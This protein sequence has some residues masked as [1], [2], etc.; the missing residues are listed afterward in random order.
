M[1]RV[2]RKKELAR[3]IYRISV[4]A[5]HIARKRRAGQF[6]IVVA[7]EGGE[8]VP[9]TIMTSDTEAGT[10]DLVFLVAGTSTGELSLLEEGGAIPHVVGPLGSP[11]DIHK[12]GTV[13]VVGGGVGAAAAC[14][15]AEAIAAAG[16]TLISIVGA[17]SKDL[18]ILEDDFAAFS[19]KLIVCT[20]D[21]SYGKAGFVTAALG[22]L[23]DSGEKID[24]IVAVG[25]VV[26]M[27]AVADLTRPHGIKTVASLNPI[28]VD[29]TGMCGGCR[30]T[31]DGATRFACVDGPEFDAHQVDFD[32]LMA[33]L[34]IYR[35]AESSSMEHF[36]RD[37]E[38]KLD[39][40][41]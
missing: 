24:E 41:A 30:V 5:P 38:C 18:V 10:I 32:E 22:E 12:V 34:S 7:R 15:I 9:L 3:D 27:K 17:R 6:V 23:I 4:L 29:G 1:F 39:D 28:M 40:V 13:V 21:G 36:R 31:V 19:D 2:V 16:N 20:D 8:R 11:T 37:H 25:P 33:R 26:M 14:P 35:D